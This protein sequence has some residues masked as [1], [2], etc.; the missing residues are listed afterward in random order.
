MDFGSWSALL[1]GLNSVQ[2]S[3]ARGECCLARDT[4]ITPFF[5]TLYPVRPERHLDYPL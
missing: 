5:F 3:E 4:K 2:F 1:K